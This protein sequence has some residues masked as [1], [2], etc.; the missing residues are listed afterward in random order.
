MASSARGSL[1]RELGGDD[2]TLRVLATSGLSAVGAAG[3]SASSTA[4]TG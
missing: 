4:A 3:G 1:A 2:A